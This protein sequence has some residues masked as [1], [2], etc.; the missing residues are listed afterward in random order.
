MV[1]KGIKSVYVVVEWPLNTIPQWRQQMFSSLRIRFMTIDHF[2]AYVCCSSN[3]AL[4]MTGVTICM[5]VVGATKL[6]FLKVLCATT[7]IFWLLLN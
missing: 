7:H 6:M 5:G 4:L 2:L 3:N 1:K